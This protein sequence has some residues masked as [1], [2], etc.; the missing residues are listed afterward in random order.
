MNAT[1][2]KDHY[3]RLLGPVYTWMAGGFEAA[4]ARGAE[5]LEQLDL[6]P[7]GTG[8]AVDLGA[9]FGMHALPLAQRGFEVTAIDTC[10]ALLDELRVHAD[11]L[12]VQPVQDDLLAWQRHVEGAPEL[13]LCMGDTL[14]HLPDRAA[15]L[16]LLDSVSESIAPG[17]RFVLSIRDY[18]TPLEK[19]HR[20]IPVRSDRD[21]IFTCFLEYTDDRVLVHDCLYEWDGERWNFELSCYPKIRIAPEWLEAALRE[22][23]FTVEG[24]TGAS[25]MFRLVAQRNGESPRAGS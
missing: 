17:G 16:R 6:R 7:E 15:V 13:I 24:S 3:E 20:F 12:P 18:T 9:G 2:A 14:T 4:T 8:L 1:T 25:G 10:A 23:G 11:G 21:R 5:E 19:E 22:R